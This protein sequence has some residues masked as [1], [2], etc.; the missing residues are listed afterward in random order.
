MKNF[1]G[2]SAIALCGIL[3]CTAAHAQSTGN[4]TLNVQI[5]DIIS[6]TVNTNTVN[7]NLNSGTSYAADQTQ[8]A[9]SQFTILATRP[10][11]LDVKSNAA[12]LTNGSN[13]LPLS[14]VQI[15]STN[16][17]LGITPAAPV[18]LTTANQKLLDEASAGLAQNV[19]M[20]Y[21]LLTNSNFSSFNVPAGT[22]TT[23]LVYTASI[24]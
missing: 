12:S 11:D 23:T 8:P 13:S 7:F 4:V 16:S 21:T 20:K 14:V 3:S 15:E 24:D 6:M 1:L 19:D 10:F 5:A 9:T 18:L 17:N 2:A 22:Y